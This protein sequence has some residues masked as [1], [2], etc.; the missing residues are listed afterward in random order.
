[1]VPKIVSHFKE[2]KSVIEL[3]NIDVYR[4]FSDVRDIAQAYVSLY[5]SSVHSETFN[6]CS[7]RIYALRDIIAMMEDI[8]GYRIEV[9]VNPEFVRANEIER[10]GGDNSK[11]V[12]QVGFNAKYSLAETLNEMYRTQPY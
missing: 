10:L 2:K 4:D 9:K 8:A 6:L 12:S 1:L 7:G 11:I 5:Q 3:G